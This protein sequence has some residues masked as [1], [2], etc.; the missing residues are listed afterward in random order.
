MDR[1]KYSRPQINLTRDDRLM[2][3]NPSLN[4]YKVNRFHLLELGS[5]RDKEV[6]F[7]LVEQ[8]LQFNMIHV[9][10]NIFGYVGHVST[11]DCT[12]VSRLWYDFLCAH[13]FKRWAENSLQH[14]ASL[15]ELALKKKWLDQLATATQEGPN[16]DP[17]DNLIYR[18]ICCGIHELREVWR[19]REPKN[20]RLHCDS[21]VLSVAFQG[22]SLFCGLNSGVIQLW[23]LDWNAKKREQEVHEKGVKCLEINDVIFITGSYDCFVKI[24]SRSKWRQLNTISLHS[25]SIWDLKLHMDTF[26]TA[27]LDGTITMSLIDWSTL[28]DDSLE[29]TMTLQKHVDNDLVSSVDFDERLLIAGYEDS[30]IDVWELAAQELVLTLRGHNGGV[31]GLQLNGSV[32]ASGSYDGTVR[33]WSVSSGHCLRVFIEPDNFVRCVAFLGNYLACGDFSGL[34]HVWDVRVQVDSEQVQVGSYRQFPGHKGHVVSLQID[35]QRIVSGSRDKTV[36]IL[37]FW[38]K[39]VD[40]CKR[41]KELSDN[42]TS[43]GRVSRFLRS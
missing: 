5:Q 34:L 24:W 14:D 8:L 10:E 38:A 3:W 4:I 42:A 13:M 43:R 18:Q 7:D 33:L 16:G 27:S 22:Q 32:I 20:K 28:Q 29:I 40:H 35:A 37:D 26:A 23:D 6:R 21:F 31:T 19:Y 15:K 30:R 9:V 39:M 2:T 1:S 41:R 12:R 17:Q 25:D 11:L 36:L